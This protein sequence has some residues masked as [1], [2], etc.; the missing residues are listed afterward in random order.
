MTYIV[1]KHLHMT[2]AGLSILF[3][4]LRA[5]WA[6]TGSTLLQRKT[7]KV[8]P[9]VIDSVLLLC[10]LALA[11]FLGA[12]AAQPWLTAKLVAVVLYIIAGSYAIK[13][14]KTVKGRAVSAAIAILIFAYI[15]GAA[16]RHSPMSWL[17]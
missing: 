11:G 15:V 3:F 12:A 17:A 5:C 7:V 10:G 14:A 6:L 1:L 2:A 13:Y 9:H 4:I 8:L 16:I